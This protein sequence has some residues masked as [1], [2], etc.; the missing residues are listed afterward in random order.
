MNSPSDSKLPVLASSSA[1]EDHDAIHR[2]AVAREGWIHPLCV[3]YMSRVPAGGG[4][5]AWVESRAGVR[6]L[7]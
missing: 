4:V 5:G 2:S 6:H 1:L 3:P 7:D